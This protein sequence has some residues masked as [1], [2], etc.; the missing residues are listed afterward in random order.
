MIVHPMNAEVP[1]DCDLRIQF[2]SYA[3]GIDSRS[4]DSIERLLASDRAVAA[5][6]AFPW[7]REGEKTLCVRVRS[8]ADVDRLFNEV[9]RLLPAEPLGPISVSTRNGLRATAGRG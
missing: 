6:E 5:V 7:G 9:S 4:A 8:E 1:G 2:G 3:M